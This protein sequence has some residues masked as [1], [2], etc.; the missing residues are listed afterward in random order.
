[1]LRR[2]KS[3]LPVGEVPAG[4][5]E[6]VRKIHGDAVMGGWCV[7]FRDE[8]GLLSDEFADSVC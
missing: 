3:L 2:S 1:M 6:T 8:L 4:F 5:K 7:Q